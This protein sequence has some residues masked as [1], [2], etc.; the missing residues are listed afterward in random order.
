M[1][2]LRLHESSTM[3]QGALPVGTGQRA[4]R[5]LFNEYGACLVLLEVAV[6]SQSVSCCRY[7]MYM[8]HCRGGVMPLLIYRQ[9]VTLY[10]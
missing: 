10:S 3:Q 7:N 9:T 8:L 1:T 4:H 2:A 5:L 6:Y